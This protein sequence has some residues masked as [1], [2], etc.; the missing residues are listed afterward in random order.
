MAAFNQ[1]YRPEIFWCLSIRTWFKYAQNRFWLGHVRTFHLNFFCSSLEAVYAGFKPEDFDMLES[2]SFFKNW[3]VILLSP[4]QIYLLFVICNF[5]LKQYPSSMLPFIAMTLPS[6]SFQQIKFC[7]KL[8][9]ASRVVFINRK[10]K[11]S[12]VG[13]FSI[14]IYQ[15]LLSRAQHGRGRLSI[16]ADSFR[17][18]CYKKYLADGW[19]NIPIWAWRCLPLLF[20]AINWRRYR[21]Q[22]SYLETLTGAK[23]SSVTSPPS[24]S[25]K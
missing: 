15:R 23:P 19:E 8:H 22:F 18:T 3:K 6:K 5:F 14:Y 2:E 4:L 12:P 25:W 16:Y 1:N 17:V 20:H 24:K 21:Q 10:F 13:L 11:R 7:G 9:Q